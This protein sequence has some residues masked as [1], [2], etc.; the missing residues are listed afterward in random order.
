M[1][2]S[3]LAI[4]SPLLSHSRFEHCKRVSETAGMLAKRWGCDVEKAGLAGLIH[5]CAKQM[6][7]QDLDRLGI[8][9]PEGSDQLFKQ[10][11]AIWHAHVGPVIA[12]SLLDVSDAEVLHAIT[13]HTTGAANLSDLD[14]ILFIADYCEPGRPWKSREYIETL[15]IEESLF[16]AG[17]AEVISTLY[18]LI[19]HGRPI[20]PD[21]FLCRE[22]FI[23][24]VSPHHRRDIEATLWPLLG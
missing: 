8:P 24:K 4:L 2:D 18:H 19:K 11:P 10:Y 3:L 22:W 13:T 7:P 6:G 5:D 16:S 21:T 9:R 23:S 20:H 1:N 15:A 17:Y 12:Q 14:L